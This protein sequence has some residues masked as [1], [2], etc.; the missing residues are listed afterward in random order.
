MTG[1]VLEIENLCVEFP[2]PGNRG[3][4]QPPATFQALS[5]IS[6]SLSAGE[7]LGL[8]GESGSGKT[9]L[10][11]AIV[12]LVHTSRGQISIN[13]SKLDAKKETDRR[14][15]ARQVQMVFQDPYSS[16]HPRKSVGD[17]LSEPFRIQKTVAYSDQPE[18]VAALLERVGLDPS[19]AARYPQHFSGG[20]RQRIAIA[21]AI[22]NQPSV[23]IADEPVSALDVSIQ[24]QILNLLD[25]LK[26]QE[27]MAMLFISHDLSVVRHL[28]QR[29][30]VMYLGRIIEVGPAK[31]MSTNPM[32]PYT[33]SLMS[34]VPRV[35]A[36]NK[37]LSKPI[38]LKGDV[39][40][41]AAI[42]SGC[43]FHTRCWLYEKRGQ[44]AR[45]RT[46]IPKLETVSD[47]RQSACFFA[48][49]VG[50]AVTGA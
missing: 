39:P 23:L 27:N 11:K 20:Q 21:R 15:L 4:F 7:V 48:D 42:P 14:E 49:E 13:G 1:P 2:A 22:A 37:A 36:R 34:A 10:G 47:N 12:G 41:H 32:H 44:P 26:S 40:S 9:T 19:H 46:D 16:L 8:I 18:Q 25:E 31:D 30:A 50:A 43:P 29:I 5:D 24:A 3:L 17:T 35:K 28:C 38:V 6:L 33:A 45:C